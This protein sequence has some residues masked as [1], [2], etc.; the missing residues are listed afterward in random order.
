MHFYIEHGV[1]LGNLKENIF[2]MPNDFTVSYLTNPTIYYN[3]HCSKSRNH[4]LN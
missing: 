3:S 2:G 4:G 1:I